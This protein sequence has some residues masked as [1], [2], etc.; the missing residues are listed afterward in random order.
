LAFPGTLLNGK[1]SSEI[2]GCNAVSACI[3]PSAI[4]SGYFCF[5]IAVAFLTLIA[6]GWSFDPKLL[7]D[8]MATRGLTPI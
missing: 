2:S 1:F 6:W 8:N 5:K 3:S 4:M 7:K